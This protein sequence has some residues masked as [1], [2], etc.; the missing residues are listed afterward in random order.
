M[1]PRAYDEAPARQATRF[2]KM[3]NILLYAGYAYFERVP[4]AIRYC[5]YVTVTLRLQERSA[6]N[7]EYND[8][9]R[10]RCS[11][12]RR[13]KMFCHAHDAAFYSAQRYA[14]RRH[15]AHAPRDHRD[16]GVLMRVMPSARARGARYRR[17][18]LLSGLRDAE[19]LS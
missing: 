16:A 19:M 2:L 12:E 11:L 15:H 8:I 10:Q 17:G 5:R 18:A 1:L 13:A 4:P 3:S 9:L 7:I 6:I 14:A